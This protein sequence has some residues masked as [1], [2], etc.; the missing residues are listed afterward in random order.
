MVFSDAISGGLNRTRH[1]LTY[2]VAPT[3]A[4]AGI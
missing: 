4:G 3:I 2:R 1:K